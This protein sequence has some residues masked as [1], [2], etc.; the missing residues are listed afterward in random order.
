MRRF[1]RL[2]LFSD[3]GVSYKRMPRDLSRFHRPK[4]RI[5]KRRVVH[6]FKERF[7][8]LDLTVKKLAL[9]MGQRVKQHYKMGFLSR[10][11]LNSL[12]DW[13]FDFGKERTNLKNKRERV[14]ALFVRPLYKI[15]ILLWYLGFFQSLYQARQFI[16]TG[17]I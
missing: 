2:K 3:V 5:P 17:K 10:R 4:W 12:F 13:G 1:N 9:R 14:S 15:D 8:F 11:I 6:L 16:D 7:K